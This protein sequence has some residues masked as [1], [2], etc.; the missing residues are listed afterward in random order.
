MNRQITLLMHFLRDTFRGNRAVNTVYAFPRIRQCRGTLF[1]G[2]LANIY[3]F[4]LWLYEKK[5]YCHVVRYCRYVFILRITPY[6]Q[7]IS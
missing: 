7:V 4:I 6:L 2:Y 1:V 5:T 3:F